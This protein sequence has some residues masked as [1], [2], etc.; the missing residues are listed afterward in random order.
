MTQLNNVQTEASM[1]KIAKRLPKLLGGSIYMGTGVSTM[2]EVILPSGETVGRLESLITEDMQPTGGR[3]Y[4][5]FTNAVSDFSPGEDPIVAMNSVG[6]SNLIGPCNELAK[7]IADKYR[8][9]ENQRL[10]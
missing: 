7:Y 10:N 9:K 1:E 8:S 3:W 4:E 2:I 6:R 5:V